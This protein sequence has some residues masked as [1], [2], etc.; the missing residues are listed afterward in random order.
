MNAAKH[1]FFEFVVG[2]IMMCDYVKTVFS[3]IFCFLNKKI[4]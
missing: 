2:C 3:F 4:K 1:I